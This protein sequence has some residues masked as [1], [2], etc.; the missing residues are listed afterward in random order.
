MA[1]GG[2]PD[3]RAESSGVPDSMRGLG[4]YELLEQLGSGGMGAVYRARDEGT[5]KEVALKQL[6]ASLGGEK[7]RKF[8][9]LFER[10]YHTLVRLKHPRIIEVY[11]YGL[12]PSGP[13]YTMELLEHEDLH[14]LAPLPYGEACR[15]LR[16]V[17]SSLA[18][19]HA[20]RLIHRDVSPRNVR[21]TRDGRAKLIDFGALCAFGTANEVVGTPTCLA[22]EA[23][24]R[25][26]LDSRTD[27]YALGV[28]GYFILTGQPAYPARHFDD[29]P[30]LW[31]RP[32]SPPSALVPDIPLA[33]DSLIMALINPDPLARPASAAAVIE[34]LT[35]IGGLTPEPHEFAAE[36][37]LAS[38]AM[39]GRADER[40]W[41]Q[42]R[43]TR[44]LAGQGAEVLIEGASGSGKT[45]LLHELGLEAQLKGLCVLKTD[46]EAAPGFFGVAAALS[47]ALLSTCPEFARRAAR[48]HLA[49]LAEL[50]PALREQLEQD[51]QPRLL[52]D[53]AEKRA[54]LQTALHEWFLEVAARATLALGR[55]QCAG[56]R[57]QLG[58]VPG[59]ARQQGP[60]EPAHAAGHAAPRRPGGGPLRAAHDAQALQ[61][62]GACR[63]ERAGMRAAG[64]SLFGDVDNSG[65]VA[66]LLYDRSAGNP[67][68]C[69]DLARLMVRKGIV[70][71]A[72]GTFILPQQVAPGEL[73]SRLEDI[74]SVKLAGL[75][76]AARGLA[77]VL[78]VHEQALPIDLCLMLSDDDERTSYAALDELLAEQILLL[79]DHSYRFAQE[80][81]R[82]ALIEQLD[83]ERRRE[84]HLHAAESLLTAQRRSAA[85]ADGR[86]VA[87]AP[88]RQRH[89]CRRPLGQHEP[90]LLEVAGRRDRECRPSGRSAAHGGRRL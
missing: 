18:L 68:H 23:L 9:L 90:R 17:A 48:P 85:R 25:M 5:G 35:A 72:G 11:D 31:Q 29:L 81:L 42:K 74:L 14:S 75:S 63:A 13:Y 37:Y 53:P 8:E 16:D 2:D 51:A 86:R 12:S 61:P 66:R 39:V 70:K 34:Q 1:G 50:S 22:P 43:V 30:K 82:A 76:R 78:C 77:E 3:M 32:P 73:P 41:V 21:L 69:M 64:H 44:V 62:S 4:R 6:S 56:R 52:L 36:S 84:L 79:E 67:Q 28:V 57:R 15:H 7:R 10:E 45:R 58:R 89:A 46:A 19:L 38:G 88:C 33:L 20:H 80:S 59:G 47:S 49:L 27:L 26:Q 87:S 60:R 54:R 55:R 71:Y 65:R 83:A 24:G 40:D